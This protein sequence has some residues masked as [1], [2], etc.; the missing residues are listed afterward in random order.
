MSS[1]SSGSSSNAIVSRFRLHASFTLDST[2]FVPYK[3]VPQESN[4][5]DRICVR[6]SC[7]CNIPLIPRTKSTNLSR[8]LQLKGRAEIRFPKRSFAGFL[9]VEDPHS[10]HNWNRRWCSLDG[11]FLH[12]W[13]DVNDLNQTPLMSLDLRDSKHD[14]RNPLSL[15]PRELCAR[16]R[17]FCLECTIRKAD[18]DISTATVFFAAETQDDLDDWLKNINISLDL[19]ITWLS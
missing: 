14:V 6:A 11:I 1:T 5:S 16:P 8:Q 13:Q 17:S 19:I 15:A 9:N 3:Y 2:D 18:E 7:I 4:N 10:Q 12:V